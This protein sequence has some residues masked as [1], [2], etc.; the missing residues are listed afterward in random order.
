LIRS[1][2]KIQSRS[3]E[4]P[5]CFYRP[6]FNPVSGPIGRQMIEGTLPFLWEK[7]WQSSQFYF[8]HASPSGVRRHAK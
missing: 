8:A 1:A 2:R 4:R 5:F 6:G 7:A 3:Q